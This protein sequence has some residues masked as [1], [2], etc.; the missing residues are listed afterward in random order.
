MMC[1]TFHTRCGHNVAPCLWLVAWISLLLC[2]LLPGCLQAE[3]FANELTR[4][5]GIA[6]PDCRIVRQVSTPDLFLAQQFVTASRC[7]MWAHTQSTARHG[8]L[9][10]AGWMYSKTVVKLRLSPL[11]LVAG[12]VHRS[13]MVLSACS[14]PAAGT[15]ATCTASSNSACQQQQQQQQRPCSANLATSTISSRQQRWQWQW[16]LRGGH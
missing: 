13:R 14:S 1:S 8:W 10:A 3:Q 5:L 2:P 15:A 9:Q 16:R 11:S 6:A 4:H 7:G 12:G